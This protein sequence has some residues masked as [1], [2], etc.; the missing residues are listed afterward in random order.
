MF[1]R[2]LDSQFP[3]KKTKQNPESFACG[4]IAI[5]VEGQMDDT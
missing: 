1:T 3:T 5:D 4:A 2:L